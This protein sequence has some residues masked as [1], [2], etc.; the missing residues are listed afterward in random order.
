MKTE[1]IQK[2]TIRETSGFTLIELLVVVAIIAIL[3]GMLLPALGKAKE[4]GKRIACVNNLH[5]LGLAMSMFA[6]DHE[7]L[8]PPRLLGQL[9]GAWPTTLRDGYRDLRL[10][11]CPSDGP[12]PNRV[13][14]FAPP[15]DADS[16]PRSYIVNGWNDFWYETWTKNGSGWDFGRMLGTQTPESV[17]RLPSE[18]IVFGEKLTESPHY[19]MDFLEETPGEL[20]PNDFTEV[21]H[22]RHSRSAN[23]SGGSNYVFADGSARFLKYWG[24]LSPVNLWGVTDAWRRNVAN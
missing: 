7:G 8:F 21:E 1:K 23:G 24:E 18:T 10:L 3:A 14:G 12:D 9:P 11:V 15:L 2:T 5:Q 19:Y 6:D 22:G 16:A 20:L 13:R 4:T 17:I